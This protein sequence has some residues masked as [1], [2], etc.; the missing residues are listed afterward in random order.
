MHRYIFM[1]LR[2][3]IEHKV[4]FVV[5]LFVLTSAVPAFAQEATGSRSGSI[6]NVLLLGCIAYFLVRSFRRRSGGGGAKPNKWNRPDQTPSDDTD[7]P[8]EPQQPAGRPTDKDEAARRTWELLSSNPESKPTVQTDPVSPTVSNQVDG[9]DEAEFLEGA[10]VFFSHYQQA[11]D[12]HDFKSIRDFI[13]DEIYAQAM[14]QTVR[15]RTEVMLLTARLME[16]K[17]ETGRTMASVFYDAQ[18]RIGDEG[19]QQEH[20]RAVWEFSRDDTVPNA[21]WVLETINNVDQ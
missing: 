10:K 5:S 3:V 19:Q 17:S 21:F 7:Q 13:S 12:A 8:D 20:L 18:L 4:S 6:L 1:I 15:G 11:A 14:A 2:R 16:M 9:F